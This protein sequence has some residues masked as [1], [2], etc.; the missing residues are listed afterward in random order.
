MVMKHPID[1][2]T[3]LHLDLDPPH[4]LDIPREFIVLKKAYDGTHELIGTL[5]P[6]ESDQEGVNIRLHPNGCQSRTGV[7]C[8]CHM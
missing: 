1:H 3:L 4:G 6:L 7:Q 8:C 2:L 5:L